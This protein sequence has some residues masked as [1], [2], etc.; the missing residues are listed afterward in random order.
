MISCADYVDI[1]FT[2]QGRIETYADETRTSTWADPMAAAAGATWACD[3]GHKQSMGGYFPP[4]RRAKWEASAVTLRLAQRGPRFGEAPPTIVTP[5]GTRC[6]VV[7]RRA[8]VP[9]PLDLTAA[10]RVIVGSLAHR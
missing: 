1:A 3:T 9:Y 5:H 2:P 7:G 4:E 6:R 8:W 10:P